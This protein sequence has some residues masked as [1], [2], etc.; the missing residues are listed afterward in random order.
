MRIVRFM[1]GIIWRTAIFLAVVGA[2]LWWANRS[3]P[4]DANTALATSATQVD[5]KVG[6]VTVALIQPGQFEPK[7]FVNFIDKIFSQAIP[8]P[9]NELAGADAGVVLVDPDRPF[10][11]ERFEPQ[12]LADAWGR[13]AD[14]DGVP[15]IEKFRRGELRWEKPSATVPKDI[16]FYLYPARKSGMRT[17]AGK[18]AVK[19]R[20]LYYARLPGG[21][22]PHEAQT[23]AFVDGALTEVTAQH[24]VVATALADAFDPWQKEMAVRRVLDAGVDT[25]VLA[26]AQPIYSD[27]EELKGSFSG[28]RKTIEAW[29]KAHGNKPV[30]IVVA[31]YVASRPAFDALI[32]QRFVATVPPATTTGAG[33]RAIL[34][35]HGL[36]VSLVGSDS[37]TKRTLEI[38][39]RLRPQ[40]EAVLKAKGYGRVVVEL[41]SEGFADTLE[42]PE[43]Q[44]LSVSEAYRRAVRAGDAVAVAVPLEF[45]AENTDSLFGH[46]VLMFDGLPGYADYAGPPADT[47]WNKPYVRRFAVGR[48]A[49]IYAGAP[50]GATLP[51]Q[52]AALADAIGAVFKP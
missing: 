4:W 11:T 50:G 7:F 32:V 42:D 1:W 10:A 37:W 28:V 18:T 46:S 51:A 40:I 41:A 34:T 15:W 12:R 2:G 24:P 48:T 52:S 17:P 43:D 23:R 3:P 13:E 29:R 25:I 19:A 31:P 5:G 44:T 45:M 27:F 35:L 8:W 14:I 49:L 16:G 39:A 36:P 20:Y 22:M 6:V 33:A 21:I 26:S 47:D 9:I 38:G 30:R